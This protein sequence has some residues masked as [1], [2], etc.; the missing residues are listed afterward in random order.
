MSSQSEGRERVFLITGASSGIGAA[1]AGA[2]AA[3]GAALILS[4]R[5][6]EALEALA[7]TLG[8]ETLVLPFEATDWSAP[9]WTSGANAL[10]IPIFTWRPWN[11]TGFVRA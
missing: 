2:F 8:A 11:P 6:R 1:L 10:K 5:R 3:E 7:A 4:G 9:R